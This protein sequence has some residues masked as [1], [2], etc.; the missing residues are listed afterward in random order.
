MSN[1]VA[2]S[3]SQRRNHIAPREEHMARLEYYI[4]ERVL[5]G[6]VGR[7]KVHYF[8][9]S[10]GAGGSSLRA[11]LTEMVNNPYF[12][13]QRG[14]DI[15]APKHIHGGPIPPGWYWIRRATARDTAHHGPCARLEPMPGTNLM[16]RSGGFLIHG[17]GRHG[18]DGC[19]VPMIDKRELK[20]F[21]DSLDG[22]GGG[23]LYVEE[24]IE[25]YRLA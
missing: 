5:Q 17:R 16:G 22:D 13:S 21:I 11:F 23:T 12:E 2:T 18:C 4:I 1:T 24:S 20:N 25:G 10:G 19:I 6:T 3:P 7:R 8:A 14:N 9:L 15:K